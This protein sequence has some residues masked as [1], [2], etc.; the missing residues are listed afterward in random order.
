MNLKPEFAAR[1]DQGRSREKNEDSLLIDAQLGL[2]AVADGM[3]GHNSGELASSLAVKVLRERFESMSS[4][5][6]KPPAY[7][8]EF[9]LETNQMAFAAQLANDIIY[10]AAGSMA[11]NKGMGTTLSAALVRSGKLFIAHV[12]DS[13]I[14]LL[15]AGTFEQIT[16]DHSLVMDQVRKG[17]ITKQQAETSSLQNI[18]TRALG[19]QKTIK[20]DMHERELKDG[21]RIFLCTDGLFKALPEERIAGVLAQKTD[22]AAVCEIM[23]DEANAAGGPDNIT[24]ACVTVK[25]GN[26]K[27]SL[28]DVLRKIHA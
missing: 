3:G 23:V 28:K 15:R 12:G 19:T 17:L 16:R 8:D 6:I 25:A 2:V 7:N 1:T 4:G 18:L 5:R 26:W 13:R 27:D 21:D 22:D 24:V 9:S 14:Y 20:I 11:E 10:E